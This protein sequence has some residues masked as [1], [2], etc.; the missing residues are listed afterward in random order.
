MIERIRKRVLACVSE[1][2]RQK[3]LI[4]IVADWTGSKY[5]VFNSIKLAKAGANGAGLAVGQRLSHRSE[6][7]RKRY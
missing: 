3:C 2:Q 7:Q 1:I 4:G 5:E 6:R